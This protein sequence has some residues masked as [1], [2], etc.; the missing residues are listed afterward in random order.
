MIGTVSHTNLVNAKTVSIFKKKLDAKESV[1][2]YGVT[3]AL[4]PKQCLPSIVSK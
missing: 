4:K 1:I 2:G 3:K